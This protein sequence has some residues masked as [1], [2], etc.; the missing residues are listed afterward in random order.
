MQKFRPIVAHFARE[1]VG[2]FARESVG[3]FACESVGHFACESLGYLGENLWAI[4][5]RELTTVKFKHG[6][7]G[8]SKRPEPECAGCRASCQLAL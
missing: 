7:V 8:T 6:D 4:I 1:S 5:A 2:H 3:H